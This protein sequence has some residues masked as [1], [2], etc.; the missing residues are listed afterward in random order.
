VK[1]FDPGS[2]SGLDWPDALPRKELYE[3]W[4]VARRARKLSRGGRVL[5]LAVGTR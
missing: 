1:C 5:E 4:E 3:S 2:R